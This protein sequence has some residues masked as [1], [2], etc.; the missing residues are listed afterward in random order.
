[1]RRVPLMCAAALAGCVN[2][3]PNY[4]RPTAPVAPAWPAG[5]ATQGPP[6]AEVDWS[7]FYGDAALRELITQALAN[8]RSLR[9]T[10]LA[11]ESARAQYRIVRAAELPAVDG[12]AT[13]VA[14]RS[15]ST[16]SRQYSVELGVSA[17]ELDFFGRVRNLRD[18]ALE[19]FL[20]SEESLRSARISLVASVAAAYATLLADQQRLRL[21]EDTL[22]SQQKSFDLTKRT[23]EVGTASALDVA[24]AQTT[25]DTAQADIATYRTLVT[26]DLNAL[27]LLVGRPL[28]RPREAT[29]E[30]A[31]AGALLALAATIGT[32]AEV[33]SA[34]LQRR[35]DVLAAERSLRAANAN[36]GAARAARFP[37]ISLT[38]S[39]GSASTQ[40]SNL[41]GNGTSTWT[42]APAVSLP[43]FDAGSGEANVR[44]AEVARESALASYEKSIQT[45]FREVAD[46]LAQRRDIAQLLAARQSLV[47]ANEKS[48]RLTEARYRRGVDSS[49][50]ALDAQRS[51]VSAQQ[52]LITAR[53]LEANN[54]IT[55]YSVLG[56]GWR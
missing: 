45:A 7:E 53:L 20:A 14:Q 21:A 27:E 56:G 49:L 13:A 25:L 8:N 24:Q 31:R 16:T 33:P 48:W 29:A 55:L 11:I 32:P 26:Q 2:L 10:A 36:I 5:V 47:T 4:E 18:Q 34:V 39:V 42:F 52:N 35:P 23:F 3:A 51:F 40:L 54:L 15:N 19:N 12:S 9:S 6:A 41:F 50:A 30:P 28:D 46:A 22:A 37:R 43:I 17:F 38:T 44:V 1:M